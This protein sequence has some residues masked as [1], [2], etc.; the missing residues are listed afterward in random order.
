MTQAS[1]DRYRTQGRSGERGPGY[2]LSRENGFARF[3]G[4]YAGSWRGQ[5]SSRPY[6]AAAFGN[7]RPPL[8]AYNRTAMPVSRS[9]QGYGRDGYGT[10]LY[11]NPRQ[12]YASRSPQGYGGSLQAYNRAPAA[13]SRAQSYGRQSY[14]TSPNWGS[15]FYDRS[16]SADSGRPTQAFGAHRAPDG[17]YAGGDY[18]Q[19]SGG[20]G[21]RSGGGS[22]G[23][24]F[25]GSAPKPSH[26]GGFHLFGGGHSSN[27]FRSNGH[28]AKGF[29]GGHA[30]GH[31]FG[32]GH[33]SNGGGHSGG[34]GG[35]RR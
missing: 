13:I 31:G 29:S 7:M 16:G 20:Y 17:N 4:G 28:E 30:S 5:G 25:A 8:S 26:S 11:S 12:N 1:V 10:S 14:G 6:Q 23:N 21:Q 3:P 34:H 24:G 9:S 2:D 33:H 27:G 19:R 22:I 35:H 18:G 32:G 15:G